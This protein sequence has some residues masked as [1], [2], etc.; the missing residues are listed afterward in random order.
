MGKVLVTTETLHWN[1]GGFSGA[2]VSSPMRHS[3]QHWWP[4]HGPRM[5]SAPGRKP[6][7]CWPL[8]GEPNFGAR[9]GSAWPADQCDSAVLRMSSL[10]RSGSSDALASIWNA[11]QCR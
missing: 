9:Q 6:G 4:G 1:L 2:L 11:I 7:T 8:R 5:S 3:H 10:D